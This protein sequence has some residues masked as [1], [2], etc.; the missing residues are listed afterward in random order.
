MGTH[1]GRDVARVPR[2]DGVAMKIGFHAD[3]VG[4]TI[5]GGIGSYVR[6]LADE[7]VD[8]PQ[9]DIRLLVSRG[10]KLPSHWPRDRVVSSPLPLRAMYASWNLLR[11]PKLRGF[12]VVHATG[13][14]IPP[15]RGAR[16]VATIHDDVVQRFPELV[17]RFWRVLYQRGFRIALREAAIL[18]A[19]SEATKRRLATEYGV[20][21]GR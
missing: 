14:V 10:T 6:C 18:C 4:H 7:L 16:L 8:D 17:P 13:I 15:A 11:A 12:D 1:G 5:P 3:A 2:S 9:E 19:N 20:D 21:A